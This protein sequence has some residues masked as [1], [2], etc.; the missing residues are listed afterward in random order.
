MCTPSQP[1]QPV[2]CRSPAGVI[3]GLV[4][5]PVLA[6]WPTQNKV[7]I[8]L[9]PDG[10]SKTSRSLIQGLSSHRPASDPVAP[11]FTS[12]R[13][14]CEDR[15]SLTYPVVTL[16][17][18]PPQAQQ[19]EAPSYSFTCVPADRVGPQQALELLTR[20]LFF[21]FWASC[22]HRDTGIFHGLPAIAVSHFP[23]ARFIR[24]PLR[25]APCPQDTICCFESLLAFYTACPG[26]ILSTSCFSLGI[27][28]FSRY[29]WFL[30]ENEI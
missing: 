2:M 12:W 4:T 23:D 10:S 24:E 15:R 6:V 30:D 25:L 11:A 7:P 19:C 20:L 22:E 28:H 26:L 1:R 27:T 13:V 18:G 3:W 14:V 9:P 16:D 5:G 21:F 17:C 29:H 8:G